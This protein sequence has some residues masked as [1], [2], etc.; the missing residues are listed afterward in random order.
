MADQE[1][2]EQLKIHLAGFMTR[3][4]NMKPEETSVEDIDQLLSI[5]DKME[6]NLK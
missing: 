5:L 3:L 1:K 2:V 6:N 4:E